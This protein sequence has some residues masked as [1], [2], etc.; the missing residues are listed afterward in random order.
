MDYTVI[1]RMIAK[2]RKENI[3]NKVNAEFD[4]LNLS[5]YL[6]IINNKEVKQFLDSVIKNKNGMT[7]SQLNKFRS[8]LRQLIEIYCSENDVE[9]IDEEID[10]SEAT[11]TAMR[12]YLN[13]ISSYKL[14][15]K[16]EEQELIRRIK[17][18]ND[19]EAKNKFLSSNLRLVINIAKNYSGGNLE[20]LMDAIGDGNEGLMKALDKFSL[21]KECKFSTYATWWIKQGIKRGQANNSRIIR[22]PVH[23]YDLVN[24]I[25]KIKSQYEIEHGVEPSNEYVANI[26]DMN[27]D[28]YN[29]FIRMTTEPISGDVVIG[30]DDHGDETRL[31]DFV[32]DESYDSNV[33]GVALLKDLREEL[34]KSLDTLTDKEKAILKMRYGFDDNI[35]RTLE[36]VGKEFGV[37]RERIRQIEYKTLKKLK[38]RSKDLKD[39]L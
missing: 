8:E 10:Y 29:N 25:R 35:P 4:G 13:D 2:K 20:T 39:Y 1:Y 34:I 36:E 31:F 32:K 24:K 6:E 5:D 28:S 38:R 15:S 21:E 37:T 18:D 17:D 23:G 19:L 14:L 3:E 30:E 9:I 7:A 26:L 22:I 11:L 16:E 12:L 33:E 27:I